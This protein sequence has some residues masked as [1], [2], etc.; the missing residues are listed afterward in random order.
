M[1]LDA[2][3]GRYGAVY[4][5]RVSI[6]LLK[7]ANRCL[8]NGRNHT[9]VRFH[10]F[11]N[12]SFWPLILVSLTKIVRFLWLGDYFIL[13][14]LKCWSKDIDVVWKRLQRKFQNLIHL[15]K[16][17]SRKF[18]YRLSL[19]FWRQIKTIYTV[20]F[21]LIVLGEGNFWFCFRLFIQFLASR[22]MDEP[23]GNT[24]Q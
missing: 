22:S 13:E 19:Y 11:K 16:N 10:C 3:T 8:Q 14:V 4:G 15:W 9:S 20:I 21:T 23:A 7:K 24:G 12:H 5:L 17:D 2:S 6:F 18:L 1:C